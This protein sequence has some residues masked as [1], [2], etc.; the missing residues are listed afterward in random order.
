MYVGWANIFEVLWGYIG[1]FNASGPSR[2]DK[3]CSLIPRGDLARID[4][5]GLAATEGL[6]IGPE[7]GIGPKSENFSW[8]DGTFGVVGAGRAGLK[9][10]GASM[11]ATSVR[12]S[13]AV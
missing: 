13:G 1:R 11:A 2:K 3:L 5:I 7:V 8:V 4:H 9:W 12:A 10:M 6:A